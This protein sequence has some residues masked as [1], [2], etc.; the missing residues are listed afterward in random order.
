MNHDTSS[1]EGTVMDAAGAPVQGATVAV[2]GGSQPYRDI[3]AVT[4]ADGAFRMGGM[5]PGS[6]VLEARKGSVSGSVNV[7]VGGAPQAAVEIRLG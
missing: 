2:A 3:A 5:H 4:S 1:I 6:Y 7:D